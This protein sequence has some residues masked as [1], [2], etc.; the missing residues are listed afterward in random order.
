MGNKVN[1]HVILQFTVKGC[2][3]S[4]GVRAS[5][6]SFFAS[7]MD[8]TSLSL[9]ELESGNISYFDRGSWWRFPPPRAAVGLV[10]QLSKRLAS[11]R[12]VSLRGKF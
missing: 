10:L 5:C 6:N 11:P 12:S 2:G 9:S 3:G 1:L 8:E 4:R 7:S